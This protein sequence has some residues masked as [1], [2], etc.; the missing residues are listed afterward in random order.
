MFGAIGEQQ[1]IEGFGLPAAIV[2]LALVAVV[3]VL[4]RL[5]KK[6]YDDRITDAKELG[7][8]ILE[9]LENISSMNKS[10]KE[11]VDKIYELLISTPRGK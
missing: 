2:I 7:T 3:I 9:P 10:S 8:R 1:V 6:S 4:A 11:M 5:L